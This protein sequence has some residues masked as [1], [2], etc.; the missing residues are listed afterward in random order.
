MSSFGGEEQKEEQ[1]NDKNTLYFS[2]F[3]GRCNPPHEGHFHMIQETISAAQTNGGKALILLGSGPK[4]KSGEDRRTEKDPLPFL[5]KKMIIEKN[6]A[7]ADTNN[8][9]SETEV[10]TQ[11]KNYL[12]TSIY[13]FTP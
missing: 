7:I 5:L 2:Y 6:I 12:N 11:C 8:Q 10:I 4:A 1:E 13:M 3:I 9:E